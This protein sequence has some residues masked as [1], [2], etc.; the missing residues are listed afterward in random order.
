MVDF[1]TDNFTVAHWVNVNDFKNYAG[2]F[3]NRS[4]ATDRVGFQT[5]TDGTNTLKALIDFGTASMNLAVTNAVPGTW[6]HMVVS[7][8]RAG[9]MRLY[10]NGVLAGQV[11]VSAFSATSITN[12]DSV[13]IGRGQST[14][15]YSG[16]VDELRIYNSA[17][18]AADILNIYNQ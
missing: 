18:S 8:D 5:R 4:S 1:G 12:T 16:A 13:R 10:V 15:Y 6:Y 2:I 14:N 3:N 11:D 17:L 9:F 7:V